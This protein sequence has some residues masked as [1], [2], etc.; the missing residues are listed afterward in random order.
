MPGPQPCHSRAPPVQSVGEGFIPHGHFPPPQTATAARG[1]A[2]LQPHIKSM[3]RAGC[4][5]PAATCRQI[6]FTVQSVGEGFIP[7]AESLPCQ[8]E[9]DAEGGRRDSDGPCPA[10]RPPAAG[11]ESLRLAYA[12]HLPLTR[13]AFRQSAPTTSERRLPCP[14]HQSF[15]HNKRSRLWKK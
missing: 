12:R 2:A 9:V 14:R 10:R 6:P 11:R 15:L 5:H 4:P 1:L 13:E 7:P 8:R 3:R